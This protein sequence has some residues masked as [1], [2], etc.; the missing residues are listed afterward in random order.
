[1]NLEL[2]M[3]GTG[4]AFAKKY[5][6]NN[7]LLHDGDFTLLIDCGVTAPLALHQLGKS[8]ADVDAVLITHIHA[9][10]V[11]GL[12]ELAFKMKFT[13][14]RKIKLYI[15]ESLTQV[16]WE[17]SLKG[18]LYQE[19]E[20]TSLEDL[21]EVC[22]LTPQQTYTLSEHIQVELIPTKHIPGKNSYSLYINDRFFYSADMIYDPDLLKYLVNERNCSMIFHDCQLEGRGEVHTTLEELMKLPED[23]RRITYLMHYGDNKDEYQGRTGG[24]DFIEQGRSYSLP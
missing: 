4:S 16:L 15:A 1:M 21:F 14:N 17:H 22:P 24:M 13:F 12:E 6:N 5:F 19:G 9:D 18:G 2:R 23:I 10:H 11:G 20:I 8:F 3:I 7:A